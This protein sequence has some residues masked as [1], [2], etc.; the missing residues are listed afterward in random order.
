MERLATKASLQGI[1]PQW[2]AWV[3]AC[4]VTRAHNGLPVEGG[5]RVTMSSLGLPTKP[6]HEEMHGIE[7]GLLST[8]VEGDL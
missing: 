7:V 1:P 6:F 2:S 8:V 4:E 3:V 5:H